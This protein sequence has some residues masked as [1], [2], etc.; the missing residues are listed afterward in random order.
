[1]MLARKKRKRQE[2][3]AVGSRQN[4]PGNQEEA[5]GE[6]EEEEEEEFPAGVECEQEYDEEDVFVMVQMPSAVQGE[7]LFSSAVTVKGIGTST[8][9]LKIGEQ[10]YNG[11]TEPIIGT[12]MAF[13]T[14]KAGS[15]G[16]EPLE[17]ACISTMRTAFSQP[18][19]ARTPKRSKS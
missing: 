11:K 19:A 14:P 16:R 3:E 1:M 9:Q 18:P 10:V 7:T 5:E 8:P 17:L 12:T 4:P 15:A 13:R 6:E 2:K